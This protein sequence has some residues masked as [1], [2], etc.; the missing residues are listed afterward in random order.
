ML[1]CFLL[2]Q[3]HGLTKRMIRKLPRLNAISSL[4]DLEARLD[5]MRQELDPRA[6]FSIFS[7]RISHE[8]SGVVLVALQELSRYL[9][10]EQA[11][12]QLSTMAQQPDEIVGV[13]LRSLLDCAA[14]YSVPPWGAINQLC[15]QCLGQIGCIDW[16]RV[17]APRQEPEF[18]VVSNFVDDSETADFIAF[19]LE[20]VLI[21]TFVSTNDARLQTF[22][23]YVMQQL[24]RQS[25][26]KGALDNPNLDGAATVVN[27]W[28]QLSEFTKEILS[29][30][31]NS[32]YVLTVVGQQNVTYP[33][34][35]ACRRYHAWLR[36]FVADLLENHQTSHASLIFEPLQ[37]VIRVHDVSVAEF[38]LPYVVLHVILAPEDERQLSKRVTQELRDILE[39][40]MPADASFADMENMK[41]FYNVS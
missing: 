20:N 3:H 24:L 26:F 9:D 6:T 29:P 40:Q 32:A 25:G 21:K 30:F 33:I 14:K 4:A 7:Q 22:L 16:N 17:D 27:R 34:F 1:I 37:R 10:K 31:L 18:V 36:Q 2:D 11:F 12:L 15:A 28:N 8:N 38:L 35:K 41:L 23:S 5:S 13:L 19:M 39:Y